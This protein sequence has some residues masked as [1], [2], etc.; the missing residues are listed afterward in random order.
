[1]EHVV[2]ECRRCPA[3]VESR[4]Q[5]VN[6]DGALDASL[7]LV[8]EAPGEQEDKQGRP[9]VGRSG[10]VLD[11]QLTTA[12]LSREAVRITNCVRC[13]PPDNR[14]P[15]SD[16]LTHCEEFL[17]A[18]IAAVDPELIMTLGRVPTTHLLDRP[19]QVTSKAGE[20]YDITVEETRYPVIINIHPAA[21]LYDPSQGD[22]FEETIREATEY[23]GIGDSGQATL[24]DY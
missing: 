15:T 5:I 3:L 21:T 10:D 23:I 19:I 13:R 17:H 22:L 12:G 8:G 18:E 9:F 16:E 1:M 14:D 6:G 7:L 11:K 2:T 24:G 20:I 4:S